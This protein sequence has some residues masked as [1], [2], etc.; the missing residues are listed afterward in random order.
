MNSYRIINA[1]LVLPDRVIEK[2]YLAIEG[3][4]IRRIGD[5]EDEHLYT[6]N[7]S[8]T[9]NAHYHWVMPGLISIYSNDISRDNSPLTDGITTRY[10]AVPSANPDS[11]EYSNEKITGLISEVCKLN[12]KSILKHKVNF[13]YDIL[14]YEYTEAV[15]DMIKA[16]C[17][18]IISFANSTPGHG[19]YRDINK[20]KQLIMKQNGLSSLKADEII[21]L[22]IVKSKKAAPARHQEKL[23]RFANNNGIPMASQYDDCEKRINTMHSQGISMSEFPTDLP[24]AWTAKLKGMSVALDAQH[25]IDDQTYTGKLSALDAVKNNCADILCSVNNPNSLLQAV[26]A[27]YTKHELDM[28]AAAAMAS[29]NP[30]KSVGI[31]T[32]TGSIE[33]G[34]KADLIIVSEKS[35]KPEVEMVFVDGQPI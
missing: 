12:D 20:Y 11:L 14:D 18:H 32:E 23:A 3:G 4:R 2:G 17:I 7:Y 9:V 6:K 24:A 27:L 29:Q 10:H 26:F 13:K 15:I 25:I 1:K 22:K 33:T 21:K 31:S 5:M 30:A 8:V 34:K 28:P 35:R 19:Q 16:D